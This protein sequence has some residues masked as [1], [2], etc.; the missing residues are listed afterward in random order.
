MQTVATDP[1]SKQVPDPEIC[2]AL[3]ERVAAS[4]QLRRAARLRE[5]L[6]YIG[7]RSLKD[8]CDRIHESEIGSAVFERATDYD[9]SVDTIVRVNATELR[10]RVEAYFETEGLHE[11]VV[12]EIPRGNYVP[13]FRYRP[14]VSPAPAHP[15]LADVVSITDPRDA[16]AAIPET[17]YRR[18]HLLAERI[19]SGLI[20]LALAVGCA[21]FWSRYRSLDRS[22]YGWQ[23]QPSVAALWSDVL[24]AR[25]DTD[26]VLADAS[27]GL[28]QDISKSSFS[29]DDYLSRR[30]ISQLQAQ[31]LN[32]E[33]RAAM[34]RIA[35]WN[36][37]SQ[38]EFKLAERFQALDPLGRKIH[39][40]NAHDYMPDLL[41]RDNVILIG[42]QIS[43][44]WDE[45]FESRTNFI[46]R[47]DSNGLIAV[48][49]RA[50]AAGEQQIYTQTDSVEY[51]AIAYLPNPDHNGIV[52][53]IAGTDAEA[54]EAAGDFLLSENQL[55]SFKKKLHVS[56]LPY[57][58]VLLKVS[59]VPGTPLTAT[60]EAY[61][62]YPNLS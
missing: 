15:P 41:K 43:N 30:Y 5:L 49:N 35:V 22:L 10:K 2:W 55:S 36:L 62:I 58:E 39:L 9:T 29:F 7:R 1:E 14:V 47:F 19:I 31:P 54:T 16:V 60:I 48:M 38:D 34:N 13:A 61:R 3:L 4:G 17:S 42:G 32:P 28:L 33:T 11:K 18:S 57:F 12:M 26:I 23:G 6:L 20:I 51:C 44:P 45:L 21:Y 8:N 53:L 27:F 46:T 59:S 52:L 56:K 37:G 25:P 50:P 24:N 40:Y